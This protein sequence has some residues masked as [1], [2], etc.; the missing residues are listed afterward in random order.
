MDDAGRSPEPLGWS[1]RLLKDFRHRAD[2]A[3]AE[4]RRA[5]T[6]CQVE[7][8]AQV[9]QRDYVRELDEWASSK[10]SGNCAKSSSG[11]STGARLMATA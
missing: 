2:H 4:A 10:C 9:L 6:E 8:T 3:F 11:P 5:D 1:D 7:T